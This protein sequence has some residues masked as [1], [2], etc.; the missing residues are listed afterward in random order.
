MKVIFTI[1]NDNLKF[2]QTCLSGQANF[3]QTSELKFFLA[4]LFYFY[5]KYIGVNILRIL[6]PNTFVGERSVC[7][8]LWLSM[9][10]L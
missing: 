8:R 5:K 2:S 4:L 7:V 1:L 9:F 3:V 10:Q 6:F